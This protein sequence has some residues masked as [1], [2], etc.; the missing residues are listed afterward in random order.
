MAK[1]SEILNFGVIIRLKVTFL[2]GKSQQ[3]V[4]LAVRASACYGNNVS[5][6]INMEQNHLRQLQEYQEQ[7]KID[8]F[9]VGDPLSIKPGRIGEEQGNIKWSA[10]IFITC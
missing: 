1:N 10:T 8:S 7:L 4:D 2:S 9:K 5:V 3:R 6:D